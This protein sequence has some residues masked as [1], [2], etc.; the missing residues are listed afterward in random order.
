MFDSCVLDALV[1]AKYFLNVSE[2]EELL[3]MTET[4]ILMDS[5]KSTKSMVF[6]IKPN[7]ICL[8]DDQVRM[9]PLDM[10]EWETFSTCFENTMTELEI[11][12]YVIDTVGLNERILQVLDAISF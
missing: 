5:I 12:Y 11:K 8:K 10:K 7:E 6:L 9:L 2:Y 3:N 1:Y 4:R